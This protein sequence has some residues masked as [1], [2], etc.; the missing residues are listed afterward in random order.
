MDYTDQLVPTGALNDVGATLKVNVPDSYR[1]GLE[2][3]AEGPIWADV[4]YQGSLGWSR[5]RIGRLMR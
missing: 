4:F 2:V 5:N 3:Q 1:L